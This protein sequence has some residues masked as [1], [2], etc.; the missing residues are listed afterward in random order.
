MELRYFIFC[1]VMS[2]FTLILYAVDKVKSKGDSVRIPEIVLI[3][4]S[5]IGGGIGAMLGLSLV[6]HK[7]NKYYFWIS[8]LVSAVTQ[9][10]IGILFLGG[11]I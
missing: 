2:L 5:A 9:M 8:A 6:H 4:L 10:G 11:S 7:S 1:G 3:M